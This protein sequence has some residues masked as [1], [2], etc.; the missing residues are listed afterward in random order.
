[1]ATASG[2]RFSPKLCVQHLALISKNV[3]K[4]DMQGDLL[5]FWV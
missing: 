3:A 2:F 4:S 5:E 1:M